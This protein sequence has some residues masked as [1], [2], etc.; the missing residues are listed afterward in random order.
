M[1]DHV[2]RL[3]NLLSATRVALVPILW[4]LALEGHI[5]A[6]GFGLVV[7]GVTDILDGWLAR[8]LDV[9]T[10][11]GAALDSLGDNLLLP[12]GLVWLILLSPHVV[13]Q[14]AAPLG[15][16]LAAYLLF[17]AVGA[18][19]FRRFANLHLYSSKLSAVLVYVFVVWEFLLSSAPAALGWIAFLTGLVAAVEG[20]CCQLVTD[21]VDE[22]MGTIVGALRRRRM[23]A[24]AASSQAELGRV[25]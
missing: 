15:L 12:S 21:D 3:P 8:R 6:V 2:K 17:L 14:F 18:I 7:A 1:T 4:V 10:P 20:L 24:A 16:W 22:H 13:A 23:R 5:V 25:A 11:E 9:V 19:R